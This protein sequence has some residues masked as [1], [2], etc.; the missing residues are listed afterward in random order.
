MGNR[1]PD[2]DRDRQDGEALAKVGYDLSFAARGGFEVYVELG[3]MDPF[4]VL[5]ELGT[6]GA[7]ADR[8]H[9]RHFENEPFGN[10]SN[11]VGFRERN[12]GIEQRVDGEG[13]FIEGRQEGA[14]QQ[15]R[16]NRRDDDCKADRGHK[17]GRMVERRLQNGAVAALEKPD[18]RA[19]ML[20]EPAKAWQQRVGHYRRERDGDD[21]TRENGDDVGNPQAAQTS[22]LQCRRAQTAARIP[23]R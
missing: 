10:Q 1:L 18:Q 19:F 5:I 14:R 13:P 6:P 20:A 3:V 11:P 12:A 9:F 7:A 4:R 15:E 17:Q 2:I 22:G 8:L 23:G 21:E 16:S